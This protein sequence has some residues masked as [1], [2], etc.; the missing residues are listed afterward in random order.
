MN[1]L[2]TR[3]A[4]TTVKI[5]NFITTSANDEDF[6]FAALFSGDLWP[7]H[8]QLSMCN[9]AEA[10]VNGRLIPMLR[11]AKKAKFISKKFSKVVTK[12]IPATC[13]DLANFLT[14]NFEVMQSVYLHCSDSKH[15][16]SNLF[17]P[18]ARRPSVTFT[19]SACQQR[20]IISFTTIFDCNL[21]QGWMVYAP[22]AG[23]I[24]LTRDAAVDASVD[25]N[26]YV[27]A[28][29]FALMGKPI[30]YD[31]VEIQDYY[32]TINELHAL[33]ALYETRDPCYGGKK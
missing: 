9:T 27:S 13:P 22:K 12:N 5:L 7:V 23:V 17:H 20:N 29:R 11:D 28:W 32:V 30:Q 10:E 18:L 15:V 33:D 3:K 19:C 14:E 31:D 16:L 4:A 2:A 6:G 24:D 21:Q 25:V 1:S 26:E 8:T